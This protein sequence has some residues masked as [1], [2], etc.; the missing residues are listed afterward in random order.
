V[1]TSVRT[2]FIFTVGAN[3][4]R[5]LLSFAS[6]MLLARWMG[7]S[8]YGEMAF[9][10]GTFLAIVPLMDMGSSAAFFT[11]LSQR[12]R[13][14]RFV[15][16]F[17]GWVLLQFLVPL[18][19][20]GLLFPHQW[21]DAVWHGEQRAL[22]LFAFVATFMQQVLWSVIQQAGES[23]RQTV[24]VQAI[25]T[26]VAVVH[27]LGVVVLW[28][29][30]TLGLYAIFALIAIEYV[31]ASALAQRT[32]SYAEATPSADAHAAPRETTLRA[33]VRYCLPLVPYS[34][35]S[36]VYG[37]ADR[38]LLQNYGGS[39]Q[40]AYYAVGAQFG[41]IALIATSSILRIF[42]KE[43]AEA[44]HGGN[45][46][47]AGALYKRVSRLLFLVGAMIAGYLIPW[48]PDLLRVLLGP[49]YVG[50]AVTLAI[51]FIYPVHQS[52]G[53]IGGTMLYA[54]ERVSIQV[55][56]G[57]AI[58]IASIAVSYLTIAP[59][60]ARIPGLGLASEGLAIKM[61]V[62]QIISVNIFAYIIAR[63]SDWPFD[64]IY[65][66]ASLLGCCALGWIAKQSVGGLPAFSGSFYVGM[67]FSGLVYLSM[68]AAFVYALP[69]LAG[70]TRQQIRRDTREAWQFALRFLGRPRLNN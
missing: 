7:P 18:L 68:M 49:A 36:F 33:Y 64:W 63:I 27:L 32:F 54:T 28:T 67:V 20:V 4:L 41:A 56:V 42:W 12:P 61:V 43:V 26:V 16:S 40:Q 17:F 62:M 57:I 15:L 59:P 47:R 51:M 25:G 60:T 38:W 37:F 19:V 48:A 58:M 39:I 65:Q 66:P 46:E 2:R 70:M 55:V 23:N 22:I 3:L 30:G 10:M 13:S 11:F 14:R 50:G 8:A 44:Y 9:L 29:A 53:Q 5:S 45:H 69:S 52:M 31:A 21:I 24:W 6:G 34:W 1:N 35:M